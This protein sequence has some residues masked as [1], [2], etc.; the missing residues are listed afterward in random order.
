M[1]H[2][3]RA[4]GNMLRSSLKPPEQTNGNDGLEQRTPMQM[5]AKETHADGCHGGQKP[6]LTINQRGVAFTVQSSGS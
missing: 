5:G 1:Q 3:Y 4:S 2:R 6:M